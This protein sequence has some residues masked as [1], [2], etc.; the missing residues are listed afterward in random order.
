MSYSAV[1][2]A[3]QRFKK[4]MEEDSGLLKQLKGL[5]M[6]MSTFKADPSI[7]PKA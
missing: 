7:F 5:E 3:F 6:K 4:Q 2:K 1:A